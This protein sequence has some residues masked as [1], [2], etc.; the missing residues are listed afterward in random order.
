MDTLLIAGL[1]LLFGGWYAWAFRA[2]PREHMQVALC[3][4]R[5]KRPD[6]RW[7]AVNITYY[8]VFSATAYALAGGLLI[9]LMGAVGARPWIAA[10]PLAALLAV[11]V[12]AASWVTYW[13]EG[14]RNGF[15]VGGASFVGILLAPW[16]CIGLDALLRAAGLPG[17]PVRPALAAL[18]LAYALGEGVGRLACI[19][20]GCCYG[21]P[22]AAC[23]PW[24]RRL[25]ARNHVVFHGATRKV[26]YS[27]ELGG[28][29][30]VPVQALTASL[31]TGVALAGAWLFLRGFHGTAFALA[32]FVT[33]GWRVLSEFIRADYRG[34]GRLSAYQRMSL[35]AIVYGAAVMVWLPPADGAASLAA[36]AQAL[37]RPGTLA[38]LAA[39]WIAILMHTGIS[40]V[41]TATVEL[42]VC[43]DRI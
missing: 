11:C 2:L 21:R 41:T 33:Q 25:F 6:G 28:H 23:P 12:P 40:R 36:G 39:L 10:L 15:T 31:Y 7:Q 26:C 24:L 30:L 42:Q 16:V 34:G 32:L 37:S 35:A 17:L 22:L 20:F 38:A 27:G 1:A 3:V 9:A 4:P 14:K 8:G 43:H 29:P 5:R 13:V 19:S 18:A